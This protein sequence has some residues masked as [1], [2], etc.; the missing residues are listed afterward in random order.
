M[1][2]N[3]IRLALLI[4][5]FMVFMIIYG[6]YNQRFHPQE[7]KNTPNIVKE[8]KVIKKTSFIPSEA[9]PTETKNTQTSLNSEKIFKNKLDKTKLI[10]IKTD[11][12][13]LDI[14]SINADI[15]K[16][17]LLKYPTSLEDKTPLSILNNE[18]QSEYI[19]Q[20]GIV[21]KTSDQP[22]VFTSDR[23]DYQMGDNDQLVVKLV[24]KNDQFEVIKTLVFK[25]GSYDIE[26][27][28][29]IKNITN[30]DLSARS[31][32]RI[33]RL[34]SSTSG[35]LL[36]VH[37]YSTYT[38]GVLSSNS[39]KY[40]KESFSDIADSPQIVRTEGGWVAMV[41]HYFLS[42]WIPKGAGENMLYTQKNPNDSYSVGVVQ[43]QFELK[44]NQTITESASFYVG[45]AIKDQLEAAAPNLSYTIDYGL[46]WFISVIIFWAMSH[47]DQLVGNWGLSIIL[48][49]L[50][51]KVLFYPLSAKSFRSMA[52]MRLLQPK[53]KLLR[54]RFGSDRQKMSQAMMELYKKEKVNP[55]GGCL[56]ILIQIPVFIALYWV[57]LESV[58]LRQAPFIFWIQ[59]LSVKD[60]YFVLPILMGLSMLIQQR[61]NPTPPDPIQAKVMMFLPVLFTFMF[62][63]FPAG[64]VL[65]WLTNNCL[66]IAQQS[67]VNHRM[68]KD[69]KFK[70][71]KNLT[72]KKPKNDNKK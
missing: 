50:L 59:D 46:L 8:E 1:K 9:L 52:K 4:A 55:L 5:I 14:S 62:A 51:I 58:Q 24:G 61:I 48:V 65:Y 3:N 12:L 49:T 23:V 71:L 39:D 26:V 42:A 11:V 64:L 69:P 47:I 33:T 17:Q 43:P 66:T 36:N 44:P 53:V 40:Q 31:Y 29:T 60:P 10:K 35:G 34:E 72:Q 27:K 70:G 7:I 6:K 20:S 30:K 13:A 16:A 22:L 45:P 21:T 25:R 19:A 41:E 37:S 54:E 28:N 67:W 32:N 57:L 56:P 18:K 68:K 63:S 38:G 15:T 2:P